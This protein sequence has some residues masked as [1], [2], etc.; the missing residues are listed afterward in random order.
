M[1][2]KREKERKLVRL[3]LGAFLKKT[4]PHP[5]PLAEGQ[6]NQPHPEKE[7]ERVAVE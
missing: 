7:N 4:S 3:L 5:S 1:I 6:P 2:C